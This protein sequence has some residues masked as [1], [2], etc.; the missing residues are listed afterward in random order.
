[1]D[2]QTE[3]IESLKDIELE[4]N[5]DLPRNQTTVFHYTTSDGLLGILQENELWA[6][7][8]L[9][10]ND[11]SE[12]VYT[13]ELT[14]D[15]SCHLQ[16][17]NLISGRFHELICTTVS[18]LDTQDQISPPE[19]YVFSVSFDGDSVPIWRQ[20]SDRNGY[21]IELE[22]WIFQQKFQGDD[23]PFEFEFGQVEYSESKQRKILENDLIKVYELWREYIDQGLGRQLADEHVQSYLNWRITYYS[24]FMKH[25][26][27]KH[28]REFRCV[29]SPK[30]VNPF[31]S[32]ETEYKIYYRSH[33][34]MI[35]PYIKVFI[36]KSPWSEKGMPARRVKLPI[37]SIRI[38]PVLQF[39]DLKKGIEHLFM[40]SGHKGPV[41]KSKIPPLRR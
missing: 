17:K 14:I 30:N 29:F 28:E 6:S 39:D 11:T 2:I 21:N 32:S 5:R 7:H 12:M 20:Y 3:F 9:F 41:L 37:Q 10:L 15:S 36:D 24:V 1:M 33:K 25:P 35:I 27:F 19:L 26:S 40:S 22:W 4:I 18:D 34:G 23:A 8:I 31:D 13:R 38:A 16:Q